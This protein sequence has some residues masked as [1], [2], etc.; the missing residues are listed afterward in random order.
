MVTH[1][2]AESIEMA[3]R[4]AVMASRPGTV[5]K[6]VENTFARPRQKR[7]ADFFA[8]EDEIMALIKT[9]S[10]KIVVPKED[11]EIPQPGVGLPA[12]PKRG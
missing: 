6:I 1:N 2:S 12:S 11:H 5:E 7:T 8:L 9:G 4:I 10:Q 3:D